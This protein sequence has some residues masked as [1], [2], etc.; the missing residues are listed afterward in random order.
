MAQDVGMVC[1]CCGV[2]PIYFG[3]FLR[4]PSLH[5][6]VFLQKTFYDLSYYKPQL[7][8]TL[9][10][11]LQTMKSCTVNLEMRLQKGIAQA[12]AHSAHSIQLA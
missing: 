1:R 7:S 10:T 11:I 6:L 5:A 9:C 3:W 4:V 8:V 12:A 2:I